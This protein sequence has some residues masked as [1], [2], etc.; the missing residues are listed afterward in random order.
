MH[1]RYLAGTVGA[2]FSATPPVLCDGGVAGQT[3]C[4]INNLKTVYVAA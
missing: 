1:G 3:T 2:N 4:A